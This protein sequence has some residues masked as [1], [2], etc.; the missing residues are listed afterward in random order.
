MAWEREVATIIAIP[1]TMYTTVVW[2]HHLRQLQVPTVHYLHY[3]RG[4]PI[5]VA[6]NRF[7]KELLKSVDTEYLFFL[8]SD[9]LPGP[10]ALVRLMSHK[11]RIV[12]GLYYRRVPPI[13]P[14]AY[15]YDEKEKGFKVIKDPG[16]VGLVEVDA[17]GLGCCLIHRSVFEQLNPPWFKWTKERPYVLKEGEPEVSED[18]YFFYRVRKELGEKVYL[19][20][21][22]RC[23]H[24]TIAVIDG[25]GHLKISNI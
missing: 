2:A 19:D 21:T 23:G 1:H 9:V 22:V 3:A 24:V 10:D 11:R 4:M 12:S 5:D 14:T 25:H 8:D 16:E 6:R 18:L 17:V 20:T 7:V 15:I 13:H